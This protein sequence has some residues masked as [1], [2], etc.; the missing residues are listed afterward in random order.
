MV[1]LQRILKL[2]LVVAFVIGVVMFGLAK[3]EQASIKAEYDR[4]TATFGEM[5][6]G[7]PDRFQILRVPT[8][9]PWHLA[10]RIQHPQNVPLRIEN[11]IAF[12][13]GSCGS[14]S[15]I[16]SASGQESLIRF[17][18]DFDQQQ[19]RCFLKHP[20]GGSTC[21][22]GSDVEAEAFRKY[23]DE[24]KIETISS[25]SPESFAQ[26]K[27][28]DLIRITAPEKFSD[29]STPRCGKDG[30][31]LLIRIGTQAAFDEEAA[32]AKEKQ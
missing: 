12:G 22:S 28:I 16:S 10:W 31:C 21:G 3:R 6:P 29:G 17:R 8:D 24:L 23:W 11:Y 1:I 15:S 20:F 4:L 27:V 32:K 13:G 19:M 9:E 26:E 18:V 2:A 25:T 30:L 5:P 7:S 14:G